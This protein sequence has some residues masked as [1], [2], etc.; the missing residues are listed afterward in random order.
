MKKNKKKKK[1]VERG[2]CWKA[3]KLDCKISICSPLALKRRYD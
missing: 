2:F 3:C 1:E